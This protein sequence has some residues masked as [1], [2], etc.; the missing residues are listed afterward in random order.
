M[1]Q[2]RVGRAVVALGIGVAGLAQGA[3]RTLWPSEAGEAHALPDSQVTVAPGGAVHVEAGHHTEWSGVRIGF[4]DG[5]VDLSACDR[6]TVTLKNVGA[7]PAHV[8]VTLKNRQPRDW[9]LAPGG[10]VSLHPGEQG[11]VVAD[12][13]LPPWVMDRPVDLPGMHGKPGPLAGEIFDLSRL[14]ELHIFLDAPQVPAGFEV[15]GI[16][17]ES[18]EAERKTLA[19]D[20]FFPFVDRFGQFAHAGWPGKI[21]SEDE[22]RRARG[23]EDAALAADAGCADR[24]R[25][26]GWS[27]GPQLKA[28]GRFRT[29][30]ADGKWWP[31]DPDG[32]LF[33]S[34]GVDGVLDGQRTGVTGRER[35]FAWLPAEGDPLAAFFTA[36]GHMPYRVEGASGPYRTYDFSKA[37]LFRKYG[38][39]WEADAAATAHRRLRAW[40]LNTLGNWSDPRVCALR[41]TP[42]VATVNGAVRTIAN[43]CPDPFAP[44]FAEELRRGMQELK[45][46]GAADDPWCIGV[47]VDNEIGWGPNAGSLAREVLRLPADRP[48]KQAY[49]ARLQKKYAGPAALNAAWKSAFAA[50]DDLL[51]NT[52]VSDGWTC[53]ADG[54]AFLDE[55]A[56]RYFAAVRGALDEAAPGLLYLGCRFAYGPDPVYRAASRHCDVV[57]VNLYRRTLCKDL[58]SGCEDKPILIGEFH[59]GAMDRGAF[60]T[61]LGSANDQAERAAL[62]KGYLRSALAH[63]RCVG[64]HWF[65]W[66]DQPLSGRGDGEN[67][68]VGF[69]MMTD[70]PYPEL[71]AAAREIGDAMYA[72]RYGAR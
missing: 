51:K 45:R 60:H 7:L 26:G 36:G 65:Q 49:V 10:S 59:F 8:F 46:C 3:S 68:P 52:E 54:A 47:F 69:V 53:D 50:W 38:A 29:E 48:A 33:F 56:E 21:H 41:R 6:L 11:A 27:R 5:P 44:G 43:Q 34:H 35:Y 72:E 64:T 61:G 32:R 70:T 12:L 57:S 40:G 71:T 15:L 19:A 14:H 13:R 4:K 66:R 1:V 24:N 23:R 2:R 17:A 9:F 28:T 31:V 22:L 37:N 25:W 63:P 42:Y 67:Y 39:E 55:T 16:V 62:Y 20:R 18:R 58:P 30:K